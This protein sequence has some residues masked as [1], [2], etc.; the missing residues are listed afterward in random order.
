MTAAATL[1][2]NVLPPPP[3]YYDLRSH[4]VAPPSRLPPALPQDA[5]HD[6]SADAGE[7]AAARRER[8][9]ARLATL[10]AMRGEDVAAEVRA[11]HEAQNGV[12]CRGISWARWG[13][14]KEEL[15]ELAGC[16]GGPALAA[17]CE[18]FAQDYSGWHGGMPDLVVWQRWSSSSSGDHGNHGADEREAAVGGHGGGRGD[19]DGK[20]DNDGN[21]SGSGGGGGAAAE[22]E[23]EGGER[24][25]FGEARLVEV[26]S[27]SDHLS[28]QQRAWLHRLASEGVLVEVCRV[29]EDERTEAEKI[30]PSFAPE[31]PRL[32]QSQPAVEADDAAAA[33]PQPNAGL[34]PEVEETRDRE[35]QP[36]A[37]AE[38]Y[39]RE[40]QVPLGSRLKL[41]RKE[42]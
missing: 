18:A 8:L 33:L 38:V 24:P 35:A 20:D 36:P 23:D 3:A 9:D 27:P 15:A 31:L 42:R 14:R 41:K 25:P 17:V 1:R 34:A 40:E 16:M 5:P 7:F 22:E 19:V 29:A 4:H 13:E 6:L 2:S 37:V 11:T 39:R 21:A 26:K 30:R 28:T 12:R 32:T 10:R